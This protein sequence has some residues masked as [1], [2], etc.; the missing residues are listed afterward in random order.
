MKEDVKLHIL[1]GRCIFLRSS[2]A[3]PVGECV[4]I[5]RNLRFPSHG[6]THR[7]A[8]DMGLAANERG[9][10]IPYT[11]RTL[12]FLKGIWGTLGDRMC[13]NRPKFEVFGS[14]NQVQASYGHGGWC[15]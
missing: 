11:I 6:T 12:E 1:L 8:M 3:L 13:K 15:M 5:G 4:K 9:C 14:R 10:Q 7:H 2:W